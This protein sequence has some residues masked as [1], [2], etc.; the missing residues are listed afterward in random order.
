MQNIFNAALP[1]SQSMFGAANAGINTAL[2]E[3]GQTGNYASNILSGNRQAVTQA[4]A[5]EI[6]SVTSQANQLKKQQAA[7]GTSR[8]GGTN[9]G[10]Q[11][12]GTQTAGQVSNLIAQARPQAAQLLNQTAGTT[13]QIG[14]AQLQAAGNLLGIGGNAANAQENAANTAQQMAN[15]QNNMA[16]GAAGDL[17]SMFLF[18]L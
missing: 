17:A 9:A 8:G 15:Q 11:Q 4:M 7:M 2:G 1:E 5:P 10:N 13:G 14:T 12:L 6:N 16:G 18:G 3:L